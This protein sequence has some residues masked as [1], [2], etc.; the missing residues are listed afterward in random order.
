MKWVWPQSLV[1]LLSWPSLA[2]VQFG[3]EQIKVGG[4]TIQVEIAETSEQLSHGLMFRTKMKANSG[5]LF[6]FPDEEK[7]SFWMKN[8]FIPLS[9]GFFDGKKIL[10]DIQD[11]QPV[12]SEMEKTPPSYLSLKP[13]KYALEMNQGWFKKNGVKVGDQLERGRRE[14]EASQALSPSASSVKKRAKPRPN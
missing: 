3:K 9:I 1:L 8:T 13:A 4:K 7:R 12:K 10:V 5:M 6:I 11:M 14:K 2:Q